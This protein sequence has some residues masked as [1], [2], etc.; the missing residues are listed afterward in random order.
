MSNQAVDLYVDP[1]CPWCW[2]TATWLYDVETVRPITTTTR[3]FSLAE[4]NSDKPHIAEA[5]MPLVRAERLLVAA[6]RTGGE[7]AIRGLYLALGE[8]HHE[9]GQALADDATLRGALQ[10]TGLDSALTHQAMAD[11]RTLSELLDEH[12]AVV[13]RGAFG[14]PTLS[15]DGSAP[16]FGPIIDRRITGAE[17]GELWDVVAP[18]L[19][20][21]R[22]FELKRERTGRPGV[23]RSRKELVTAR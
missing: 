9:E 11:D 7:G 22:I 15:V 3:L 18:V 21:P 13:E 17:V 2:L 23:G 20:H 16:F 6:R 10:A 14:V 5:L 19:T 1:A 12:R 8:A 4:V